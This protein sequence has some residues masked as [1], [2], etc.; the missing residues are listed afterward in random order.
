MSGRFISDNKLVSTSIYCR[1]RT[2][3]CHFSVIWPLGI[4][5]I[6]CGGRIGGEI[7]STP[8]QNIQLA[9]GIVSRIHKEATL[10]VNP[11]IVI[12]RQ[13][14][15]LHV[16]RD[17]YAVKIRPNAIVKQYVVFSVRK[18]IPNTSSAIK[19]TCISCIPF[20]TIENHICA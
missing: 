17:I 18:I 3:Y 6:E 8:A 9:P 7:Q 12:K 16:A 5:G 15:L 2:R 13:Y 4:V 1:A 20:A 14:A 10:G 11:G 19:R